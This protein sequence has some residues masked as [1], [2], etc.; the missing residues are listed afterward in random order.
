MLSG[1]SRLLAQRDEGMAERCE[2]LQ[3]G[4]SSRTGDR[5]RS[6]LWPGSAVPSSPQRPARDTGV[7]WGAVMGMA[8]G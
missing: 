1:P 5:D 3:G 8:T 2:V 6:L 7:S 4:R